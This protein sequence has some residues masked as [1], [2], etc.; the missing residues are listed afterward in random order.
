MRSNEYEEYKEKEKNINNKK[1]AIWS[2]IIKQKKKKK[3]KEKKRNTF[4]FSVQINTIL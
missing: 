2:I 3:R 4:K 1:T